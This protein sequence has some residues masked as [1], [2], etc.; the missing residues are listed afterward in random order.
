MPTRA[1][2]A[3]WLAA[4]AAVYDG[5]IGRFGDGER[6]LAPLTVA[7]FAGAYRHMARIG[8]RFGLLIVD[9]A[10]HFGH[11]THD[12]ALEMSIAPLRIGLTATPPEPGSPPRASRP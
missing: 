12:E 5:P 2:L 6:V 4:L 10:H 1:L 3:Q 8:D 7:T 9:E 11:G